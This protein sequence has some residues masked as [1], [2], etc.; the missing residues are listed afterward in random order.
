MRMGRVEPRNLI[1][2]VLAG[3]HVRFELTGDISGKP[4]NEYREATDAVW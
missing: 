1:L 4:L 2:A 3:T